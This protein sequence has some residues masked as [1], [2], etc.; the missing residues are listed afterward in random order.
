M[1]CATYCRSYTLEEV[2]IQGYAN[3]D[4]SWACSPYKG[5]YLFDILNYNWHNEQNIGPLLHVPNANRMS[6]YLAIYNCFLVFLLSWE[7][8]V[9]LKL[10]IIIDFTDIKNNTQFLKMRNQMKVA[11]PFSQR[12]MHRH[13]HRHHEYYLQMGHTFVL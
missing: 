6:Y 5:P 7:L 9:D 3:L 10:F 1:H 8:I 2:W 13:Y 12:I 11:M 4:L